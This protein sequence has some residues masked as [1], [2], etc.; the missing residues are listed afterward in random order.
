VENGRHVELAV[1]QPVQI[2][3]GREGRR[4]RAGPAQ[5]TAAI[6]TGKCMCFSP[7]RYIRDVSGVAGTNRF[8]ISG[9]TTVVMNMSASMATFS[10]SSLVTFWTMPLAS[11]APWPFPPPG[12]T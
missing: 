12:R 2:Q 7:T 6:I 4:L 5:I 3:N 1:A 10:S 9:M 11:V 8:S